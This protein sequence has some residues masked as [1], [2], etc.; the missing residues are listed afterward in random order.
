MLIQ[1]ATKALRVPGGTRNAVKRMWFLLDLPLNAHRLALIRSPTYINNK[2]LYLV[3]HFFLKVDM[4]FT[5][6]SLLP[7][8]SNHPNQTQ[9]PERWAHGAAVGCNLREKLIS[10]RNF[11]SLWRCLRGWSWDPDD[12]IGKPMS[13]GDLL[14]LWARHTFA[15][16]DNAPEDVQNMT[17]F[18]M[19][20][21][22]T[23]VVGYERVYDPA[24]DERVSKEEL[25]KAPKN[26]Y[27][28]R[29]LMRPDQLIMGECVRRQLKQHEWWIGMM[30]WGFV[31]A[32]G[33]MFRA[34]TEE[35]ILA[36]GRARRRPIAKTSASIAQPT[37][38][39]G[40]GK[41]NGTEMATESARDS[42]EDKDEIT[43]LQPRTPATA[44][45]FPAGSTK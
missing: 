4:A 6:P 20:I 17:V 41:T 35:E 8:P 33:R 38:N 21:E 7:Y 11:T 36:A 26:T 43:G 32:N 37:A 25:L 40:I 31:A 19:K 23:P 42:C 18:G 34:R 3:T 2:T 44:A 28:A 5:D 10:E 30:L 1:L 22:K 45:M 13:E 16:P 39:P 29:P 14:K 27:K 15:V 9:W 24:K 12:E